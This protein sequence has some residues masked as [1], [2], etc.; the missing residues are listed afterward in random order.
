M[1]FKSYTIKSVN[2]YIALIEKGGASFFYRGQSQ[3]WPLIPS[4]GRVTHGH[5]EELAILERDIIREFKRVSIPH[6]KHVPS[7]FEEWILHAQHYGLPTR[8]LD[9]TSN[10]LKA[11]YFAVED[12]ANPKDGVV[13]SSDANNID[14]DNLIPELDANLPY[15]FRPQHL[16]ERVIAQESMFLVFPITEEQK[17]IEPLSSDHY[18]MDSFGLIE[19]FIIPNEAKKDIRFTLDTLGINRLSIYPGLDGAVDYVKRSFLI[20]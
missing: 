4:L 14:W 13:Y 17:A 3:D 20:E 5:W 11:L 1:K 16:N 12:M 15:F 18:D 9:W 7:S 8:L 6:L 19:K 10:P 2:E